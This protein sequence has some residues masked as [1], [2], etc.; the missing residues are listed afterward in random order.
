MMRKT[1]RGGGFF[2]CLFINLLLNLEGIECRAYMQDD[3]IWTVATLDGAEYHVDTTWG[4]S[5]DT[6][7]Y[8]YFAMTPAQSLLYHQ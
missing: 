7:S 6:M 2:L 4:D 5:G 3:H 1:K 8:L